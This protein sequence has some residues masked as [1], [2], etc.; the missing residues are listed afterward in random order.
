MEPAQP[1]AQRRLAAILAADVVGFSALMGKDEEGTHRQVK[2]LERE[3]IRPS[4][5][6]HHGRM[7]KTTGDGFLVEFGSPVEAV[8]A[9]LS[10]QK[11]L[12][13][14][15]LQLRMGINLG[16]VIIEQDGD[17]YGDGVNV[18]ARLEALCDP[19][20][21]LVSGKVFDE[22]EGKVEVEFENRGEQ[23]V[24]NIARPV[25]V[26]AV[27]ETVRAFRPAPQPLSLPDKPSIAVLPF[28]NLSGDPEQDYFAEGIAEELTTGLARLRGFFVI[29]RSSSFT[30]KGRPVH[31]Q[32]VGRD[33][34][35]R[36][37]VEGSVRRSGERVRIGVRLADATTGR[38][39]WSDR[40]DRA[41]VDVFALQDEITANV[42]N[43]V[44]PQI[45]SA[46]RDRIHQKQPD[47]LNAW[48]YLIRAMPH[49]WVHTRH[50]NDLALNLL[51]EALRLNPSYARAL[52]LHAW[53]SQWLVFHG[54]NAFR[55]V[56]GPAVERARTAVEI[57]G[58]DAW[59]RLALGFGHMFR[60]EHEDAVEEL[61]TALDLNPNFALAHACLS[62]TLS[63][64]SKGAEAVA[65]IEAAIRLSPRDPFS[66]T[67]AGVRSF[68][69]F[70]AGRLW[71]PSQGLKWPS[72]WDPVAA[73]RPYSDAS[74][75]RTVD[76]H[77][78]VGARLLHHSGEETLD[79]CRCLITRSPVLV[80]A[81]VWLRPLVDSPPNL[82]SCHVL[83]RTDALRPHSGRRVCQTA[84]QRPR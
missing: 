64:G 59:A 75:V 14:G 15:P 8:R 2:A 37:V 3:V 35:V 68:A 1:R 77:A 69:H 24:K 20:G 61:R 76:Q 31:V 17:V 82:G 52:G 70:I 43:A 6:Q 23:Q 34:G 39:V 36:Y 60:R 84:M 83:S 67:F 53:L 41:V 50:N 71:L 25:R 55:R 4:V 13:N 48:D 28:T 19:G 63:Y 10:I 46:E 26:Y 79:P 5:E 58:D 72:V 45:Y 16:D 29:T 38:E 78:F 30:Y 57:D 49:V 32:Q 33:L 62:L 80:D 47:D 7:V 9:A 42:V 11:K 81:R 44:E 56:I 54:W 74:H 65:E 22:V 66:S 18:A 21:V 27:A 51:S 40:Y 12:A 73:F